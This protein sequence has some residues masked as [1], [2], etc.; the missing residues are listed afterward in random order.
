M[1][2]MIQ[3]LRNLSFYILHPEFR[4][5][6]APLLSPVLNFLQALL[7]QFRVA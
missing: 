6:N 4:L 1:K 7:Q 5:S 3:F 2:K